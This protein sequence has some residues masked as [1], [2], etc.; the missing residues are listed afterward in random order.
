MKFKT[1]EY[2]GEE[3]KEGVLE[4]KESNSHTPEAKAEAEGRGQRVEAKAL[5]FFSLPLPIVASLSSSKR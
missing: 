3:G 4:K 2:F 5:D 1:P